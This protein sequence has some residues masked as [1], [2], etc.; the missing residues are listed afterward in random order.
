MR[1]RTCIG[2]GNVMP[3]QR[4]FRIAKAASGDVAFDAT[5]RG[6]GRGAYVCSVEC[7]QDARKRGRIASALKCKVDADA[8][9]GI[10]DDLRRAVNAVADGC[11]GC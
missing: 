11:E 2:C 1:E 6:A 10:E 4:M 8:C 3:K 5:G 7:F 9:A